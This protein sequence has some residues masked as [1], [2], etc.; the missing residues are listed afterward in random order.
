[1]IKKLQRNFILIALLSVFLVLGTIMIC[2]NVTNHINVTKYAD[3]LLL[4]IAQNTKDEIHMQENVESDNTNGNSIAILE[5]R[6]F[7]VRYNKPDGT[8]KINTNLIDVEVKEAL[9][10]CKQAMAKKENKGYIASYRYLR[11]D[12]SETVQLIF[13]DC[14]RQMDMV[15]QFMII[16]LIISIVGF[17]AIG[18]I[19]LILS[20]RVIAPIVAGYERQKRFITDASHELKT[21]LTIIS[22]N[23]ELLEIELGSNELTLSITK[24]VA[25]LTTMTNNLTLLARLDEGTMSVKKELFSLSDAIEDIAS[26]FERTAIA[27][28]KKFVIDIKSPIEYLG[29]ETF[30]R[31]AIN[32]LLDNALKYSVSEIKL[33]AA[34]NRTKIVI[35][36]FNDANNVPVGNLEKCFERFYRADNVRADGIEGSGIGLSMAREIVTQHKGKII[37]YSQTG[38]DFNIKVVL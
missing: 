30:M 34:Y 11:V 14:T 22:A 27:Q 24:Q 38:N 1:M 21:P 25:R 8:Y 32:T 37:A 35:N 33:S 10:F 12:N 9:E 7:S 26:S 36:L 5:V 6:Y 13:V 18:I 17:V 20:K 29:N 28:G 3:D 23:T 16:S 2:I 19:A 4:Y 15:R 31:Q